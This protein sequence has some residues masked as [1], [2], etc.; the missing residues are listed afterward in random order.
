M[1]LKQKD[2]ANPLAVNNM[3]RMEFCPP[4]FETITFDIKT[5][6]RTISN[7]LYE[8]TEGR[9]FLGQ[10]NRLNIRVGFEVHAEASY[11]GLILPTIN[12]YDG[13]L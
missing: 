12:K 2:A 5:D 13:M 10:D 7:W 3:R 1:G 11:F 8:N 6:E 9:F 4:H